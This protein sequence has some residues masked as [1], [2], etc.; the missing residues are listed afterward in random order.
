M[1][2]MIWPNLIWKQNYTNFKTTTER[3]DFSTQ[4]VLSNKYDQTNFMDENNTNR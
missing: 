4:D 1:M 2:M 3:S